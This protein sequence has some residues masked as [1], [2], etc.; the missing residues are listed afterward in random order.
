MPRFFIDTSDQ[1]NFV[2]DETG[3]QFED[4]DAAR[5]AAIA[6]LPDMARDVLPDGDARTFLAI[7]RDNGGRTLLQASL[8]LGVVWLTED[9]NRSG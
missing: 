3:H 7:V 1:Q 4:M 8:S 9:H 5:S 6:A 2:R